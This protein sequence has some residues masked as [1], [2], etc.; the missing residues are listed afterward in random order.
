MIKKLLLTLTLITGLS[1]F[2]AQAT[3]N[4]TIDTEGMHAFVTFK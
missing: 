1:S 4:Y 3:E 2:N